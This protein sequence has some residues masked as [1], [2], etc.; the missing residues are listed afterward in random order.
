MSMLM[1]SSSGLFKHINR[2]W[3]TFS[4]AVNT[5]G[6]FRPRRFGTCISQRS[7]N[8]CD[9]TWDYT[10]RPTWVNHDLMPTEIGIPDKNLPEPWSCDWRGWRLLPFWRREPGGIGY[11]LL[12]RF[13]IGKYNTGLKPVMFRSTRSTSG[14]TV[15]RA[16]GERGTTFYLYDEPSDDLGALRRPASTEVD[17]CIRL[18]DL[19]NSEVP[20]P[21][22][23]EPRI[24]QDP[25][26]QRR[27]TIAAAGHRCFFIPDTKLP[28]P[29][30]CNWEHWHG[31]DWRIPLVYE[32]GRW[33]N[34][35]RPLNAIMFQSRTT[36]FESRGAFYLCDID[37]LD[38]KLIPKMYRFRGLFSSVEDFIE[39]GDWNA[40]EELE[41]NPLTGAETPPYGPDTEEP[42]AHSSGS[43]FR[44]A[45]D[46]PYQKRTLWDMAHP[47][48]S[49]GYE[50]RVFNEDDSDGDDWGLHDSAEAVE[51]ALKEWGS[52]P[53]DR[54]PE[55][56]SCDWARWG[57]IK[58]WLGQPPF[59]AGHQAEL[60]ELYGIAGLIPV[61]F[62]PY[63]QDR[64]PMV[65]SADGVY[66]LFNHDYEDWLM[67][68]DGRYA[69]A[70]DFI[71]NG[72]W[73]RL[74]KIDIIYAE[75]E[76]DTIAG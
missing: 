14:S 30:T 19:E 40:M 44:T 5:C 4:S 20:H 16:Y 70:E 29:W 69:S 41:Y 34:I 23:Y 22:E 28:E 2:T 60:Q 6:Q 66:Y 25:Y 53:D 1:V 15:F 12:D 58:A 37:W 18:R 11:R 8:I 68:F 62:F 38:L 35:R 21:V 45:A 67:R 49:W 63:P 47:K 10:S 73:N 52:I 48:G 55:P 3:R 7:G 59:D 56:W 61:M 13:D 31:W 65:L 75:I 64:G 74:S 39:N 71:E 54:L 72:D 76:D 9:S 50:A 46:Q 27:A 17:K 36:V 42:S 32:V 43:G 57:Y 33:F 51:L 26:A 24:L